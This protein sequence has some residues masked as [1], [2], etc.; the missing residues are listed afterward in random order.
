MSETFGFRVNS[1]YSTT[2]VQPIRPSSKKPQYR[3][4]PPIN[5]SSSIFIYY[6][7]QGKMM[8]WQSSPS[9]CIDQM[10]GT[11]KVHNVVE[12]EML[13]VHVK[14]KVTE[15]RNGQQPKCTLIN[16]VLG[17]A[18]DAQRESYLWWEGYCCRRCRP[19]DQWQGYLWC[20]KK[21]SW[22]QVICGVCITTTVNIEY[23]CL[24]R[25]L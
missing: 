4:S 19:V 13:T 14:I 17:S 3:K 23:E 20:Y 7:S 18:H 1:I 6:K 12:Q 10:E 9:S 16:T 25:A 15:K 21:K 8:P 11:N 5:E 2:T 24:L 22:L